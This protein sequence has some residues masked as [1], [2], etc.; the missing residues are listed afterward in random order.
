MTPLTH[1]EAHS[2][3]AVL[4]GKRMPARP[5]HAASFQG[6]TLRLEVQSQGKLPLGART[7]LVTHNNAYV[8]QLRRQAAALLGT[9]PQHLRL[10]HGGEIAPPVLLTFR[11]D[12]RGC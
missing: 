2:H 12:W 4:Q 11:S 9:Q 5:A 7:R 3:I 10:L 8:G 1:A 6:H